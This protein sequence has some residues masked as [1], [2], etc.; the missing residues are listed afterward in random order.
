MKMVN[1][2]YSIHSAIISLTLIIINLC[3]TLSSLLITGFE[4]KLRSKLEQVMA[5]DI[6]EIDSNKKDAIMKN[7]DMK[8]DNCQEEF[9]SLNEAQSHYLSVHN[10]RGYVKCCDIKL[11]EEVL[12][13][14]HVAYHI[15]P[16]SYQSVF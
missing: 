3:E 7:F 11:R 10:S 14:E 4:S 13:K 6:N 1:F 8:C 15:D 9:Q 5:I 16:D 12:V 2:P